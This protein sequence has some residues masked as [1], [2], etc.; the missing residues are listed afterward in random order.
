[1]T[2]FQGSHSHDDSNTHG[3]RSDYTETTSETM[4]LPYT[5]YTLV[6]WVRYLELLI[7]VHQLWFC[8]P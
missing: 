8:I 7:A 2:N 3:K 6:N 5:A 1:M 4:E